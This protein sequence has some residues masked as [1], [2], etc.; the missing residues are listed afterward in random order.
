MLRA[1]G[2]AVSAGLL[3]LGFAAAGRGAELKS[4]KIDFNRD[5]RPI[6]SDT[7]FTC[8]GPDE[9]NRKAKLRF[10][11][12]EAAFLPAKSGARPIVPGRPAE[13][14]LVKRI[15][16]TDEDEVMPP[17]KAKKKLTPAQIELLKRWIAEGATWQ[18]HW[19]YE[20]PKPPAEPEVK[21]KNWSRNAIDRFVLARLEKE[22]LKPAPEADRPT[23]IR[24]LSLDLTGL[25]P[26]PAEIDDYVQDRSPDA[27]ERVVERLLKSP[28]YGEHQAKYWL[29]AARYAD[30]HGF[31]I[32][33]QRDIWAY[34]EW[35]INAFN[36]NKPY[37]Q[38]TL[39]Q[40]AGDLL[41]NPT[42][43][44]KLARAMCAAT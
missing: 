34:R 23:L 18:S 30:S 27:Y 39:E 15:T 9:N 10:D 33:S 17:P 8:H 28:R 21:R 40:L 31:H 6:L 37:D 3:V 42:T 43:A 19:A 26:T 14:E 1:P 44:Q 12:K 16:S 25:P 22:G 38:F 41:P 2:L 5:I 13:S 24:R 32:D 4:A 7:C 20:T 35:V 11:L 36:E 29:D